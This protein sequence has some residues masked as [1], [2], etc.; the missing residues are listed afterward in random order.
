MHTYTH[1]CMFVVC[2]SVCMCGTKIS[3]CGSEKTQMSKSVTQ[4]LCISHHQDTWTLT[5]SHQ[6]L[7]SLPFHSYQLENKT[8]EI[9]GGWIIKQHKNLL[10][11]F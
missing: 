8:M 2:V 6:Y 1:V 11:S 7:A 9:I 4:C 5:T 10:S 3:E